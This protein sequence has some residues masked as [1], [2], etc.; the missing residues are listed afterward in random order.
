MPPA[1]EGGDPDGTKAASGGLTDVAG[2]PSGGKDRGGAPPP[3]AK[4]GGDAAGGCRV[5]LG[6]CG[7]VGVPTGNARS[8]APSMAACDGVGRN[9]AGSEMVGLSRSAAG[10]PT[11]DMPG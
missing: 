2:A 10:E 7:A 9:G 11:L 4:T 5:G 1:E 8:L 3:D 6:R